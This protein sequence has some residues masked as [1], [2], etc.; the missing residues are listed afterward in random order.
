LR[1]KAKEL[2]GTAPLLKE[3]G[4]FA[5][6]GKDDEEPIY[7]LGGNVAE[8]VLTRDGKGKVIG[9]SADCPADPKANCTPA[10]EY[11]GFRVVRG[12]PKPASPAQ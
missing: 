5:G 6:K 12:A 11:V 4:S 8:W 2:G 9:G 3:V 10:Q 7:D 1:E